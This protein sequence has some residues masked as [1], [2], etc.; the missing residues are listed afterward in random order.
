MILF[1]VC[2]LYLKAAF[3]IYFIYL[4]NQVTNKSSA[5]VSH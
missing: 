1:D 4:L 3:S 5:E 2:N